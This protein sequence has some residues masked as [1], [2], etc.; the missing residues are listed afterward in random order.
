MKYFSSKK[1][2]IT[3]K[4][5][6]K[7]IL[8]FVGA[9]KSDIFYDLGCGDASTCIEAAKNFNLK[10][11]YGVEADLKMYLKADRKIHA[12]KLKNKIGIWNE[13]LE[14]IDFSDATII[15]YTVK[16]NLIHIEHLKKMVHNG[17]KIITPKIPIPSIKPIKLLQLH[18]N[19]FIMEGPLQ[20]H[21]ANNPE[22][23]AQSLQNKN[24]NSIKDFYNDFKSDQN[25]IKKLF[26]ELY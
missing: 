5:D 11:I 4:E 22:E 16:P 2:K 1:Q 15:Y 9:N 19:Y 3:S 14:N 13:F 21:V 17:C 20:K 23:W 18:E 25:W 26:T 10:K 24:Y 6:I 8:K 12:N 7:T